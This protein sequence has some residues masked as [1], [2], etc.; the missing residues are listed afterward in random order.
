MRHIHAS[1]ATALC[2]AFA[3]VVL[4][5]PAERRP[6]RRP[7]VG[8]CESALLTCTSGRC[9]DVPAWTSTRSSRSTTATAGTTSSGHQR[10]GCGRAHFS[11]DYVHKRVKDAIENSYNRMTNLYLYGWEDCPFHEDDQ[12]VHME[13]LED[14][15]NVVFRPLRR[16]APDIKTCSPGHVR[17]AYENNLDWRAS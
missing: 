13:E 5:V 1:T 4:G 9:L 12:M 11:K 3:P 16:P 10:S 7:K 6:N 17:L 15:I 14:W 8:K 2:L